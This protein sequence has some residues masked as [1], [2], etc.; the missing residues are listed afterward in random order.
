MKRQTLLLV[1]FVFAACVTAKTEKLSPSTYPPID[2]EEVTVF[3]QPEELRA[4]TIGFERI[5]VI[6][7]KGDAALT[8][9]QGHLRK[10]RE[11][12]AKLGANGLVYQT[13]E[14]GGRH[15]WFWGT[16]SPRENTIMA[17]RWWVIPP[18]KR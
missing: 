15:N 12:A 13:A 9:A 4:D 8:D 7:T 11:E 3:M 18:D 17:V 6:F 14:Q 16:T 2:P 1:V 5:A 10:A